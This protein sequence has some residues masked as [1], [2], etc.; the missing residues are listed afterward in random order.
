LDSVKDCLHWGG[1]F[2]FNNL[3][4]IVYTTK[5][6]VTRC[7]ANW[8]TYA[9]L[10]SNGIIQKSYYD[11]IEKYWEGKICQKVEFPVWEYTIDGLL[12]LMSPKIKTKAF[13]NT[14]KKYPNSRELLLTAIAAP[15]Y[16]MNLGHIVPYISSEG[17]YEYSLKYIIK[18]NDQDRNYILNNKNEKV[19]KMQ[20]NLDRKNPVFTPDLREYFCTFSLSKGIS[21]D[22]EMEYYTIH[23]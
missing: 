1:H 17:E 5:Y 8:I 20:I 11:S 23:F 13:L 19:I 22:W 10:D 4:D 7:D 2:T 14:M 15:H 21:T 9:D 16:N 12:N 6:D 3:C 18:Y